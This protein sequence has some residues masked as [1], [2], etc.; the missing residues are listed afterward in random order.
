[1]IATVRT[2]EGT[3]AL[4]RLGGAGLR[5]DLGPLPDSAV[6][7]LA[8]AAGQADIAEPL[9]QRTRGHTL[10]VVEMLRAIAAGDTGV[11]ATLTEAVLARVDR[12]GAPLGETIRAAA[13]LGVTV[14]PLL[15]ANLLDIAETEAVRRCEDLLAARLFAD[16]GATYEFANDLVQE[17]V[18][19]SVP[20]PTAHAL[21]RRAADLLVARPEAMAVHAEAIDDLSRAARGW[22]LAAEDAARRAA[23]EDAESLYTRAVAVAE[24]LGDAELIGRAHLG[25]AR[26]RVALT[27]FD[28]AWEDIQAATLA[29][30]T[31]GD[32]RL[33]LN[34]IGAMG[35]DVLVG[36]GDRLATSEAMIDEGLRLAA[37][38]GDRVATASLHGRWALAHMSRLR[39]DRALAASEL[40]L[41]EARGT[42]D[43][44]ALVMALDGVKATHAYLGDVDRLRP[45]VEELSALL[46]AH[47]DPNL[48]QWTPFEA[49][50]IPL[51]EGRA[52]DAL[53]EIDSV[54]EIN[55]RT[56]YVAY[57][58]FFLAHRAWV[59]RLAGR[60]DEAL[61]VGA[62]ALGD[63][64]R[65][66]QRWWLAAAAGQHA[67]ALLMA[68][69]P[70]L[71]ERVAR[72]GLDAARSTTEAYELRCLAP[73]AQ[74]TGDRNVVAAADRLLQSITAPPGRAWVLGADAYLC[75]ARA[76][77]ASGDDVSAQRVL[78]PL[79]EATD[80][81]LWRAVRD[82]LDAVLA[83]T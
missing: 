16:R 24:R 27:N 62:A 28:A 70:E 38:L 4:Q 81:E 52:D 80:G 14:D 12:V 77:L 58:S 82:Q 35:S 5:L 78:A 2:D 8:M 67:A 73:L 30:R 7:A 15:L 75:G 41:Q 29:A 36:R 56:G 42:G 31:S 26:V 79:R 39:F 18:L 74:A 60:L 17:V 65:I 61:A 43:P 83:E 21:H 76:H 68:G 63:A 45:I 44:R 34:V 40:A 49:S 59:L 51:A 20:G 10:S 13:V 66:G 57:E 48:V 11:P 47:P 1:M 55:R 22:M 53:A 72:E 46:R 9:A 69:Q 64:R 6:S 71:A 23:L 54:V 3:E 37:A 33:Q 19:A 25:R 50:F 32:R